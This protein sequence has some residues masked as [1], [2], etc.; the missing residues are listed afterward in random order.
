MSDLREPES[1]EFK[2]AAVSMELNTALA[3]YDSVAN[4]RSSHENRSDCAAHRERSP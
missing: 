1:C 3:G 4:F 2:A